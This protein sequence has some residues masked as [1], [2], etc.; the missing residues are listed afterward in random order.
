MQHFR[1]RIV[2]LQKIPANPG[3]SR[4]RL[5][6]GRQQPAVNAVI[7]KSA[8]VSSAENRRDVA[9]PIRARLNAIS[10][11]DAVLPVHQNHAVRGMIGCAD[12]TDLRAGRVSAVIAQFGDKK[13]FDYL[14]ILRPVLLEAVPAS[15]RRIHVDAFIFIDFILFDPRTEILV[16]NMVFYAA[17][18]D[19]GTATYT[20]GGINDKGPVEGFQIV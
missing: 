2:G 15:F 20:S 19:A 14:F 6:A 13:A 7:T 17:G 3:L 18:P 10:A 12:W 8:F 5:N 11:T 4:A 16:G 1:N 9:A